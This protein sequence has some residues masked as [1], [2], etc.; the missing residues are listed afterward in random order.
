MKASLEKTGAL[1][2]SKVV[3]GK[4][5]VKKPSGTATEA[6]ASKQ[7]IEQTE[8][9]PEDQPAGELRPILQ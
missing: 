3:S 7:K 6:V 5:E 8:N 1:S 4:S 9:F 2:T